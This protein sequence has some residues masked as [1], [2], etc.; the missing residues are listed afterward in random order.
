[1]SSSAHL[2]SSL[3]GPVASSDFASSSISGH[4]STGGGAG[5][6][7]ITTTAPGSKVAQRQEEI[8]QQ[9]REREHELANLQ[10]RQDSVC[11]TTSTAPTS[12]AADEDT[13]V[14]LMVANQIEQLKRELR[15]LK[16]QQW[17]MMVETNEPSPP[18]Y[19]I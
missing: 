6:V 17:Q 3:V 11:R 5:A 16:S 18:Q 7:G 10:H 2:T 9:F 12:S 19:T 15:G 4:G 1:M 14:G 8:A 13:E